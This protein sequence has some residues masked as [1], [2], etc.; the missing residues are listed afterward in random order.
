MFFYYTRERPCIARMQ[1][2]MHNM[3]SANGLPMPIE[4]NFYGHLSSVFGLAGG[5]KAT[6]RSLTAAGLSV[7]SINMQLNTHEAFDC[8]QQLDSKPIDNA[9]IDIIHTNPNI[10]KSVPNLL[11]VSELKSPLR[12]AYWAWE[13]EEFP[14]GWET[15][16]DQYDEIWCPSSYCATALIQRSPIPVISIPHL[17]DW[18][19][20]DQLSKKRALLQ[21]QQIES[22]PV[23]FLCLFDFWSTLERKNPEAVI[24]SFKLAFQNQLAHAPKARLVIKSSNAKQFPL[25]AKKISLIIDNDPNIEWIDTLLSQNELENLYL[26]SDVFVSLHRAEGF[27]L[28]IAEAMASGLTVIA[29]GYSG[30]LEFMPIGSAHLVPWHYT[31][32]KETTGDYPIGAIW[33][34]PCLDYVVNCMHELVNNFEANRILGWAGHKAVNEILNSDKICNQIHQRIGTLLLGPSR[35]ELLSN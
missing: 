4:V 5:A 7:N 14:N 18:N 32:V 2:L 9:S 20:L 24:K 30:N 28:C 12:I 34:E 35:R 6:L 22:K 25:D 17:P 21:Q 10:L 15:A 31:S 3:H 13:L 16:F 1:L 33:A 27:G 29:T 23:Q 19:K 26:K 8:E 11:K